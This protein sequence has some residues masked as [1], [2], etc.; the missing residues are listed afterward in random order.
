MKSAGTALLFAFLLV[1]RAQAQIDPTVTKGSDTFQYWCAT[2][3]GR[4]P[5]QPGTTALTAKYKG[6]RPG[7]LDER[8]DL[9]PQGV[10]FAVRKGISI[11]PFFRKTE[12]T[13]AD[14]DAVVLY[15]TRSRNPTLSPR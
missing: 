10:R 13:D 4:G 11:M 2:C 8:T 5:G 1:L 3:H 12:L 6:Q 14:L 15:L 7:L 9:T